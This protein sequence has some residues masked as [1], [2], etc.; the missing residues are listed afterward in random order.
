MTSL[1]AIEIFK[2]KA[3]IACPRCSSSNIDK[4]YVYMGE[5][6]CRHCHF[7]WRTE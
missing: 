5:Y 7:F 4:K 3:E 1:V 6:V 2:Y